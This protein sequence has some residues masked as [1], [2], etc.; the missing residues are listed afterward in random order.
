M[1]SPDSCCGIKN[2]IRSQF[3]SQ[4]PQ[5]HAPGTYEITFKLNQT[6]SIFHPIF[7]KMQKIAESWVVENSPKH[8]SFH[9][10]YYKNRKPRYP[11]FEAKKPNPLKWK[12]TQALNPG[13]IPGC[14]HNQT[15]HLLFSCFYEANHGSTVG[16][17]TVTLG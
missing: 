16:V 9:A 1:F 14:H 12:K 6:I 17:S 15:D 7:K 11:G 13:Q 8:S 10:F 5:P 3:I 2:Q 4:V